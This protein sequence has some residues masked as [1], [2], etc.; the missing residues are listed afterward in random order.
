MSVNRPSLKLSQH[1]FFLSPSVPLDENAA[2]NIVMDLNKQ[3]DQVER[4][5]KKTT[6]ESGEEGRIVIVA[7]TFP[8]A[9][10]ELWDTCTNPEKIKQ[11]FSPVS[12]ELKVGGRFE[13][14]NNAS[15]TIK[16]CNPPSDYCVTWEFG[17]STSWVE[18]RV[19]TQS[20]NAR[21][22]LELSHIS[23]VNKHWEEYGAGAGG[24]GWEMSFAGLSYFLKG[25]KVGEEWFGQDET[26]EYLTK[27]SESWGKAAIEGGEDTAVV[28]G[29]VKRTT[30]FYIPT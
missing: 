19:T 7:Q 1:D 9:A 10:P 6:L 4:T 21:S 30:A 11:F 26:K 18:V 28:E 2:L 17:G 13:V 12:G 29:A 27:C 23:P 25:I 16:A 14:Q 24:V 15:G 3:L 22:R 20:D 5:V 8:I